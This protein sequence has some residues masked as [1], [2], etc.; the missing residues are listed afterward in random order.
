MAASDQLRMHARIDGRD[1][2]LLTR[3][4]LDWSHRYRRTIEALQDLKVK[5][6]YLDGELC[7]LDADGVPVFSRLQAA[8]DE[9]RTDQFVFYAFNLDVK[10]IP[11]FRISKIAFADTPEDGGRLDQSITARN[12]TRTPTS[13]IASGSFDQFHMFVRVPDPGH[14]YVE[15]RAALMPA[16]IADDKD[17]KLPKEPI[18]WWGATSV[19]VEKREP[20]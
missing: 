11:P 18:Y 14:Y 6:A 9:G 8:M 13:A 3:T 1:I 2:K 17:L 16:D 12:V 15:F 19:Q 7:A 10:E 4:G 5:S 20:G